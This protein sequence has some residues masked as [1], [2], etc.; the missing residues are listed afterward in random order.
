MNIGLRASPSR[1]LVLLFHLPIIFKVSALLRSSSVGNTYSWLVCKAAATLTGAVLEREF[2]EGF[3]HGKGARGLGGGSRPVT[4]VTGQ[5]LM[6]M[7]HD[8]F[9]VN[10]CE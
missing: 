4:V 7:A 6:F 8:F 10:R 9:M 3:A 1:Q 5:W 2:F